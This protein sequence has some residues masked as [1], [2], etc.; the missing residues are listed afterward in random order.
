MKHPLID[1]WIVSVIYRL[2]CWMFCLFTITHGECYE[3]QLLD[4][5]S[6][7][8]HTY[9]KYR[10]WFTDVNSNTSVSNINRRSSRCCS[11]CTGSH[12]RPWRTGRSHPF[13][14]LRIIR[15]NR[16]V[17]HIQRNINGIKV[18]RNNAFFAHQLVARYSSRTQ[19]GLFPELSAIC[20][21]RGG[22]TDRPTF[23]GEPKI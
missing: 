23:P 20:Y 17:H 10:F 12:L 21:S 16:Q 2:D 3:K 7:R 11:T 22:W 15:S 14:L 5:T 4:T 1:W 9:R 6:Y 13:Y 19:R 8:A 18:H